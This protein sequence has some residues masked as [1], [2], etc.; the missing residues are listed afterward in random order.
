MRRQ[1]LRSLPSAI[2]VL[3]TPSGSGGKAPPPA[4]SRAD[5]YADVPAL[6]PG[7]A[8]A[9]FAEGNPQ[10]PMDTRISLQGKKFDV[11]AYNCP[12]WH[13]TT[14]MDQKFEKGWTEFEV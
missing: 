1:L 12:G 14:V 9:Y 4:P 2:A 13:R 8:E 11:V 5:N 7:D 6:E 3:Q 10:H